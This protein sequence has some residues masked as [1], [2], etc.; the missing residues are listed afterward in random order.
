MTVVRE[1]EG[2]CLYIV[3]ITKKNTIES[4]VLINLLYSRQCEYSVSITLYIQDPQTVLRFFLSFLNCGNKWLTALTLGTAYLAH[5]PLNS[6]RLSSIFFSQ[7]IASYF[8]K[9]LYNVSSLVSP[10]IITP[11]FWQQQSKLFGK[12]E[13]L[14]NTKRENY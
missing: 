6:C 13:M 8:R 4:F 2:A 12:N 7:S 10:V 14:L 11:S 1:P 5:T 9:S 3:Q